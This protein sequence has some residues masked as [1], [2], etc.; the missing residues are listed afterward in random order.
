MPVSWTLCSPAQESP[1][2]SVVREEE[3]TSGENNNSYRMKTER[4]RVLVLTGFKKHQEVKV[5]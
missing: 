4:C 3:Q 2:G 1:H 5:G